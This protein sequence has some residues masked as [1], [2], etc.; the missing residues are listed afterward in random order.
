[1]AMCKRTR[2]GNGGKKGHS[3]MS[4]WD[5]TEVIK[6]AHK[7]HLRRESKQILSYI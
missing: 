2:G 4:H 7:K 6:K 3:M 1:M 5:G